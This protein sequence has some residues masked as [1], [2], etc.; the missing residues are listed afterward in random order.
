MLYAL[1]GFAILSVGDAVVKT[2]AGEW[3]PIAVAALRFTMGA[4][5]LAAILRVKEGTAAFRPRRLWLQVFRGFCLAMATICFFTAIYFIPLA[6]ATAL[7]FVAPIFTALLSGPILKEHATKMTWVGSLIA[8]S[9]V[10]VVLR[11]NLADVGWVA[12]LPLGSALFFSAMMIANRVAASQGSSL[13]MQ[14]FVAA[15]AAPILIV[16]AFVGRASGIEAL[17]FGWP[18]VI[19][20]AKCALVATTASTAHWLV[21]IGTARAGAAAV[22]PMTYVQLLV[23]VIF[24]WALFGDTPDLATLA[25][26]ATIII[27]GLLLWWSTRIKSSEISD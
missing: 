10:L 11:P 19:V 15:F 14:V 17:E 16:S 3:S 8:F 2:M 23:A 18:S 20:V 1:A 7:V 22:A 12:L 4:I 25:G 13:S 6:E 21:Y 27:A 9:G 24:G 5:A 26:A